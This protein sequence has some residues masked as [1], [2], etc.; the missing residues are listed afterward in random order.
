[1]PD[2]QTPALSRLPAVVPKAQ[3]KMNT[4]WTDQ[5]D[6]VLREAY[7]AAGH[8]PVHMLILAARL[9]RTKIAIAH[10]V[11]RL[12]L[13][14]YGRSRGEGHTAIFLGH[15]ARSREMD[16]HPKGMLGKRHKEDSRRR[17]SIGHRVRVAQGTHPGQRKRSIAER[18]KHSRA[19]TQW[20]R[21]GGNAYSR[22]KHGRRPDIDNQYFRSAWEANYARFLNLLK[23]Q[24]TIASWE[25]EIETFWFEAVR[26][27]VRSYTPD[28]KITE[29][30]GKVYFVEV[31]GWMD[32]KSKTKIKRMAKYHPAVELRVVGQ[33]AYTE[34]AKKLGGAI[35]GWE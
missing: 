5:D 27:G 1:M 23:A 26:R 34:I 31:K 3:E 6:Q 30:S 14:H 16:G 33:K 2:V 13:S 8:G 11:G 17:M 19:I 29:P 22:C 18:T 28:F 24:G 35:A 32:A 15:I 12:G 25:Y 9:G 21:S 20:M 10:R 7:A 4:P